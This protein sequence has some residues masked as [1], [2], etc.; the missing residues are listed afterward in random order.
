VATETYKLLGSWEVVPNESP[1][2]G[3]PDIVTPIEEVLI[4]S[5]EHNSKVKLTSDAPVSVAFGGVTNAHV[6]GLI[7]DK[8]VRVRLTSADGSSQAIPVDGFLK[9]I[10]RT[11]P[12]TAI[13]LT[14][15]VGQETNVRVFLGEK[16]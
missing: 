5:N 6:V 4:L 9:L 1:K 7:S 11:V 12:T 13:D 10:S 15:V 16:V 2:R 3:S 14:R 8:K